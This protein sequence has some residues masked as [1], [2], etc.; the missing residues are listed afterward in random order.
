MGAVNKI[1]GVSGGI[2]PIIFGFYEKLI[3]SFSRL[4]ISSL[5]I[6]RKQGFRSFYK[7]INGKFLSLLLLGIIISFFSTS[8]IIGYFLV[9]YYAQT[10]G[11]FFGMIIFS[12]TI[13]LKKISK[14]NIFN[15]IFIISGFI[16]GITFFLISPGKE[17]TNPL[18]VF[19]CGIVSVSG[20]VLPGL[21]G[22]MILL[23]LGNYKLLLIDSVNALYYSIVTIIMGYGIENLD[24]VNKN[25]IFLLLVF[26]FG[27]II[28]LVLF[29]KALKHLIYKFNNM[30]MS[31]LVGFVVGSL[32]SVWPWKSED[33]DGNIGSLFLKST[34]SFYYYPNSL[35]IENITILASILTGI[36]IVSIM[37]KLNVKH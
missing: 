32:G 5:I 10:L 37:E 21:S 11:F 17:I 8:L 28:G 23:A 19:F 30:I 26:A 34:N 36:F 15:I 18:F 6:L 31:S 33:F 13:I 1:P 24:L 3:F 7:H 4:D 25:L 16:I 14:I 12:T 29:S 2:V 35:N 20:M 22:S 9:K 27:S